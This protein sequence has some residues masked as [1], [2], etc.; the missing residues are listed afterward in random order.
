MMGS[1]AVLHGESIL[2]ARS[3]ATGRTVRSLGRL[4]RSSPVPLAA[5][6]VL[7]ATILIAVFADQVAPYDPLRGDYSAVRQAPSAAH[8]LG[9][10]HL[11]RDVLSRI[12][13]GA[14]ISLV[15]GFASV[16]MG[17]SIGL[18]WGL[19]SGYVGGRLD[20]WGQRVLDVLLAFPGLILATLL[21]IGLGSGLHTVIFAIAITRV[22]ASTRVIRAVVLSAKELVYVDAARV[23]GASPLRIVVRHI[24]PQCVAPF[25]VVASINLGFAITTEAAL[26]FM[27]IGVPPPAP[28]WGTMLGGVTSATFNPPWWLAVFPGLAIAMTVLAANLTGDALRDALDPRLKGR[29]N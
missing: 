17:D 22:P 20:L 14:R 5:G 11:G 3:N 6:F 13:H 26:S 4:A 27:G 23:I 16:L 24:A 2:S 12:I 21:M 15:V 19:L 28:S 7:I 10:D 29:L 9:T 1:Q 18:A 8:W 25:L